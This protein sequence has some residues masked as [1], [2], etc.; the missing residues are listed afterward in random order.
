MELAPQLAEMGVILLMFGVGLHFHVKDL[1]AV[2][3]VAIPGALV[4]SAVATVLGMAVAVA[5]GWEIKAG[6]V[7]GMAMAVAST[8]VLMRVL[9][10][11]NKLDS[12]HGHVAVGW[13]IVEDIFTVVLL[14][15]IP[16]MAVTA[17]ADGGGGSILTTLVVALVKLAIMLTL[18]LTV[19]KKVIPVILVHVARL[20][21]REL[22]TLTVLVFAVAVATA[23]AW[24]FGVSMALGAFL[25]GMAVGQSPVS[26]Q[27]AAEALPLRD[28][29]AVIFFV[30]V[31]MMFDPMFV[32]HE[33]L[34]VLAALGIV[35][36]GKPLAA[37]VIV[38]LLGYSAR[39][40]L[41]VA[42]G[43]AQIGEFSFILAAL[44]LENGLIPEKGLSM[45]VACALITITLNP[46]LF[47][48]AD[49]W[50]P[51]LERF[52]PW[53]LVNF[54]ARRQA[55][56]ANH[57]AAEGVAKITA[58]TGIIVGYGPVGRTADRL[59]RASGLET[60]IIDMNMDTITG[61]R[62]QG[63]KAIFGDAARGEVLAQAGVAHASTLILTVPQ[64]D[65]R[66]PVMHVA[67]EFN[68]RITILVRARF[69]REQAQLTL[70]GAS[71]V[72]VE[73]TEAA[74]ALARVTLEHLG[75]SPD[76]IDEEAGRIR[77][78]LEGATA[79]R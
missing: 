45:L 69:L 71:A 47:R 6:L 43:L 65:D 26:H 12:F 60:V 79:M 53:R 36:I 54:R 52:G 21:S 7:I 17:D 58:P 74:I 29:F 50:E 73:E 8:V 3:N 22:F 23:A 57:T 75:A 37:L 62:A 10:D 51:R 34:L 19:G 14:V 44:G 59:L 41:T 40:A 33:P 72:C 56:H 9:I 63:R 66:A 32:V 61:L 76:A 39:T 49:K 46:W 2:R 18:L 27:A 24:L 70:L 64:A 16:A 11:N 31:G 68:P 35:L 13:L 55:E 77:G 15:L 48:S 28:A 1:L 4:Q 5:F 67:R 20:R 30:S 25:A 78:E 42:V 38:G